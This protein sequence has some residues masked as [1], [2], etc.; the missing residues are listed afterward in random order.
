MGAAALLMTSGIDDDTRVWYA[1]GIYLIGAT[2]GIPADKWFDQKLR[3]L[4]P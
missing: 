4:R 2:L 1:L 3:K